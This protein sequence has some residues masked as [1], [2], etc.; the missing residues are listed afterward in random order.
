VKQVYSL[1]INMPSLQLIPGQGWNDRD[2]VSAMN[3][4]I[5][6]LIGVGRVSGDGVNRKTLV[7]H[8]VL[9]CASEAFDI[10]NGAKDDMCEPTET[11]ADIWID[12]KTAED[13]DLMEQSVNISDAVALT[14]L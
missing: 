7:H 3:W 14:I 4:D 6:C 2:F 8:E 1:Q 5:E 13:Y 11:P 10:I 9:D 12:R